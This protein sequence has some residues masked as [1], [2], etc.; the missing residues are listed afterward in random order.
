MAALPTFHITP[1]FFLSWA[2][3]N[4]IKLIL[5]RHKNSMKYTLFIIAMTLMLNHCV[6]QG[7]LVI[8]I[9]NIKSS[10]GNI[11]L[12]VYDNSSGFM[13][14]EST[15]AN[16]I[17][18]ATQGS[19][20]CTLAEVKCGSFAVAVYHD[21]NSNGKLDKNMFGIPTEYYG[22][23]NDARGKFGPPKFSDCQI[24]IKNQLEIHISLY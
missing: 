11:M 22:F 9:H 19:I 15:Y 10:K 16:R 18:P 2:A 5:F 8:N 24:T 14:K 3:L 6:A 20:Q 4:K 21:S 1:T 23:S 12:A 13:N 7:G 17:I